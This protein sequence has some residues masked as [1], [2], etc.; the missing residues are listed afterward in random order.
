MDNQASPKAQRSLFHRY[1]KNPILSPD[2]WPYVAN[3]TFNPG[4]AAFSGGTILLVRVEDMRGFSHLTIARSADGKTDWRVDEHPALKPE[5]ESHEE[6]WG[7][8][9]P[10]IVFLEE[11]E[12]YAIT[13]VSFSSSGPLVSLALTQDFE[14]FRRVGPIMPPEDKD[15]SLFPRRFKG[16]YALIHR[17]IIRGE[18]DIWISFSPDLMHWGDHRVL[19]PTRPGWWDSQRV[20]LGTPPIETDEGWLVIYHGIRMTASGALYRVGLALLDLE[21]PWRVIRRSD[22]WVLGPRDRYQHGGDVPG[23][24]FPTGAILDKDT[25]I[26]RIYYGIADTRVGLVTATVQELLDYILSCPQL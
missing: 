9:D 18:G 17:P 20:G 26:L 3:A 2:D 22:E 8:E 15:A 5:A 4:A 1:E 12:E 11:R 7:L 6:Q 14:S 21:E 23:V 10:R 16:R 24:T 25:G 19:L 13:Y